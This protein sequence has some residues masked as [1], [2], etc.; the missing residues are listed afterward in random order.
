MTLQINH[1][2]NITSKLHE[3]PFLLT[4]LVLAQPFEKI[5]NEKYTAVYQKKKSI[6]LKDKRVKQRKVYCNL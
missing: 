5:N 6:Q 4:I 1:K 2:G 3:W